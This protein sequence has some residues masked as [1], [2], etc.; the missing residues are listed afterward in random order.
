MIKEPFQNYIEVDQFNNKFSRRKSY[1]YVISKVFDGKRYYKIGESSKSEIKR[2]GD[3]NTYLIPGKENYAYQVHYL[4]FYGESPYKNSFAHYVE[5]DIHK[6]LRHEFDSYNIRFLT[7]NH[8]EWYLPQKTNASNNR[9]RT[10]SNQ[11]GEDW[12][13]GYVKGLIAVNQPKPREAY[14][15]TK[16]NRKDITKD[17]QNPSKTILRQYNQHKRDFR[18]VLKVIKIEK[19]MGKAE[20]D[21]RLGNVG[22]WR[23]KLVG[24]EFQDKDDKTKKNKTWVITEV[25]YEPGTFLNTY[26]VGYK[27]KK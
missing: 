17:I 13:F 11:S 9:R 7:N 14:Q 8:S 25:E 19:K 1:I 23:D 6:I 22:F 20:R 12:F 16:S 10:R 18:D 24:L 15:F 26:V 4:F 27:V 21:E 5:K 2:M 3:A